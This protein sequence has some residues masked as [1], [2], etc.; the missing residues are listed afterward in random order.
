VRLGIED[1][2]FAALLGEAGDK[3]RV[4]IAQAC[5][6]EVPADKKAADK[7]TR[8]QYES[9]A[10]SW[11]K[12][13]EGGRELAEKLLTLD[14]WPK[15]EGRLMPFLNAIRQGAGQPCFIGVPR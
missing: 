2:T 9:H 6:G 11:F 5:C 13:V 4:T 8:K 7:P 10:Q 14:L 3:L 1:K 12:S 15:F